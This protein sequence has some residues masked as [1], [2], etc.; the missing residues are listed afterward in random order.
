MNS[1][2]PIPALAVILFSSAVFAAPPAG[3]VAQAP[4][5]AKAPLAKLKVTAV[6]AS[7]AKT[8][9]FKPAHVQRAIAEDQRDGPSLIVA[10]KKTVNPNALKPK[11]NVAKFGEAVHGAFKDNVRG[12]ALGLRKN[13]QPVLTLIWEWA[14]SP[15][16]G[17]KG[18]T[19][20]TKMHVASVSKLMTAI[21]ATKMLDERNLSVDSKIGN[22]IPTYW[23]EGNNSND[24]TFRELLTHRAAFTVYDGDYRSFKGQI[25]AGVSSSSAD[26]LDYTNGTFSLVRVLAATMTGGVARNATFEPPFPMS[27]A[28][29]ALFND[30]MWDI[31]STAAFLSY[32]QSKVFTPSGVADVS[33]VPSANGAYAYALKGDNEGWNSGDVTGQLGGA[34]FR[35]SVNEVLNVMGTFRRKGTIV[36]PAKAKAAIEAKLGI[37]QE[38]DTPAGKIYNKNGAWRTG[39]STTDDI[40]QSVAFFLQE[41]MECVVLV[42]GWIG[43]QQASLRNT[44][45][46]AYIA[47]LE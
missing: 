26:G 6:E 13:G 33:A 19:L 29:A 31:K 24:I 40:E 44:I 17:S 23:N 12:Y 11:L 28:N 38:I 16:Q 15:T 4:K 22:Y 42:N 34:G 36:S 25:E 5:V 14:R 21:I 18:W 27:S 2:R 9:V 20:D 30:A 10:P 8:H 41:D 46:D 39:K 43:S 3:A 35:L 47:N 1:L 32:A 37:D 7:R 45:R